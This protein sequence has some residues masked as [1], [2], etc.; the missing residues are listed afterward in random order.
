MKTNFWGAKLEV[1]PLGLTHIRLVKWNEMYVIKGPTT[2]LHNLIL[3]DMYIEHVG[4]L[5][6]RRLQEDT[7]NE[8]ELRLRDPRLGLNEFVLDF[9]KGGWTRTNLNVVEGQIPVKE[10]S[11]F[12]WKVKGKWNEQ[13]TAFNEETGEEVVVFQKN[14]MPANYLHM[15]RYSHFT[16]QLNNL[17]DSLRAHLAPTDSRLRPD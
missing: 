7:T 5:I 2:I 3:G 12:N 17:P 9:K 14:E 11:E 15:Y 10:Y 1:K 13:I 16:L 4:Q 6:C 8:D